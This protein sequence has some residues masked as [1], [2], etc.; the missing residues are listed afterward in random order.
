L[1]VARP[2]ACYS[3]R[4]L[5]SF[6]TCSIGALSSPC[7][8]RISSSIRNNFSVPELIRG[9][10][11]QLNERVLLQRPF[12]LLTLSQSF[13]LA[14]LTY[15]RQA[16]RTVRLG[17]AAREGTAAPLN[18]VWTESSMTRRRGLILSIVT[19]GCWI[20]LLAL[21]LNSVF[22]AGKLTKQIRSKDRQSAQG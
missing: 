17:V 20:I 8:L 18:R 4:C 1:A 7:S 14:R 2:C 19:A 6:R 15:P 12:K 11:I 9:A 21:V 10:R 13:G 16:M 22:T 5:R 3:S